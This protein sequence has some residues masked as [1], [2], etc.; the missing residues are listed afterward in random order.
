[1]T[2]S[3]PSIEFMAQRTIRYKT[4]I[5]RALTEAFRN[6]FAHHPDTLLER[7][8]VTIDYP[9]SESD[10]PCL[11]VRLFERD[12]K[13]AGI[14]HEEHLLGDGSEEA[15]DSAGHW[16]FKHYFYHGDLEFAVYGL[17]SKDRDLISD[18]VVQTIGMGD[19][20]AYTN[21]FFDRIYPDETASAY[22]DSIWH[23]INIDSDELQGFG[24]TQAAVPWGSEDDLM[25]QT[26]YR[27]KV[28]G[29]F[30]SVPP[31]M[32]A[33][34]VRQVIQY[35]YIAGVE[36]T[37]QGNPDDGGAWIGTIGP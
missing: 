11:I 12:I 30:Y 13:N 2:E 34:L 37:P 6:V 21:E 4:Y 10:Y 18:T 29:E 25:Y 5:K 28:F 17:S 7:T 35:P 31:H 32:P 14:A 15:P 22:P 9:R 23:Y 24:E 8:K 1:M 19:L 26:S 36:P 33:E 16:R 27:V 20:A 3:N